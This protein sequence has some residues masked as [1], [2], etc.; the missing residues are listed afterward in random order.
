MDHLSAERR[1]RVPPDRARAVLE[2]R[3][4]TRGVLAPLPSERDQNYAVTLPDGR[5]RVLKIAHPEEDPAVLELQDTVLRRLR[6]GRTGFEFPVPLETVDGERVATVEWDGGV[7]RVRLMTWVPGVP[8]A[9]ARPRSPALLNRI[10]FMLGTVDRILAGLDVEAAHRTL[11][12]DLR[13]APD[14]IEAN[15]PCIAESDRR[16]LVSSAA[17]RAADRLADPAPG[18]R[19]AIVHNDANDH[20]VLVADV[21]GRP[22][23]AAGRTV[24]GLIDFG[25]LLH[26]WVVSEVAVAAAYA[27]LDQPDPLTAASALTGGYHAAHP[28]TEAELQA[29]PH[30][31]IQ[32]LIV[33]VCLSAAQRSADPGNA[34]L[35][36]SEAPAWALLEALQDRTPDLF[37]CLLRH[38]CGL[39][40]HPRSRSVVGW[41]RAHGREAAPV[42]DPDPASVPSLVFDLSVESPELGS[43]VAGLD[44]RG[45][46]ALLFGRMAER[47]AK[48]GI[49][50]YD[51]A[52]RWYEGEAYAVQGSDAERRTLHIGV[53][54]FAPPGTPVRAPLDGTVH[55]IADN[56]APLDYGPTLILEHECGPGGER[57]HTLFGHL[58]AGVLTGL[59]PG[60][61]VRAGDVV[62]E[63][64]DLPGN[65]NWPP[66]LH[67]QIVV[68]L[69]GCTGDFPGVAPPAQRDVWLS[70]SP[71]PNLL[72]GLPD[73]EPASR[74]ATVDDLLA[75]RGRSLGPSLSVSYHE[76]LKIVRGQGALLLDD[77]GRSYL[78]CVNNVAH[79]GHCHPR[80][81]AAAAEQMGVLN[82]NTRYL[83]EH[84]VRY[85]ERLASTLPDPLQV[86][87]FVCSGSEANEL[88]LRM[89]QAH[90]ARRDVLVLDGAYHGNTSS[91]IELSPYKFDGPG[92]AGAP[93]HVHVL[94][95]P[96][97]YR[98]PVRRGEDWMAER[99]AA[100]VERALEAIAA[101]G[102]APAAFF[103]ESVPSCAGQIVLPEG[104]LAL[105]AQA[106]RRA[107][108]V[109][110][111]D[112][113][114]VG[115]GR[116]G[117]HFWGFET[118]GVVPDIV[119][120]GKPMG[121]GHP[122]GA[123]V[124]TPEIARSFDNGMEYFNTFGGNPV[125]C[126]VGLAVLDVIRDEGL[127]ERA[128]SVGNGLLAGLQALVDRHAILGDAR[129]LGL[130]LGLELVLDRD[131]RTPAPA[132]AAHLVERMRRH[133]ILLST[134]GPDHNVIK[135][136]PPLVFDERDAQRLIQV[137]D[138]VLQE[139]AFQLG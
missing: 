129:G 138:Q 121:N 107:G 63:V 1:P 93:E 131:A 64:G 82:T 100:A 62:A 26:T 57:F 61:A 42:L 25:D 113:V 81:V 41:L 106:V 45:F 72:L 20:N 126:A 95:L 122:M 58:S 109:Y 2:T 17:R 18:L 130:F 53:D 48:V 15:A 90:T 127:Q 13:R 73:L 134:D 23:A 4:A 60:T 103:A 7:H 115:F 125:S 89:A 10:G 123:V 101:R 137:L 70:L 104:Y 19:T 3:F 47:G 5:R 88:A 32:R 83:H 46:T 94:T 38:A 8:L 84:L 37:E 66:H 108:G 51:E 102:S 139:D 16:T 114:Q 22:A 119:T 76:P 69:L 98:G 110:V 77:M 24:E 40:P 30:L 86:C 118:Q 36:V 54:L 33:S 116:V 105:A 80:V 120:M 78:D 75:R 28:L 44:A 67:F 96:D 112:E 124:T 21:R 29:L 59:S 35:S 99:Y 14:V 31:V 52:R 85:A 6:D 136:K 55:S 79:V 56:A 12:W 128:R 133:G 65:G 49:G 68:D 39:E 34:Y 132:H 27:M 74:G 50:R 9:N 135:I 87:F 71:D 43:T 91:L 92:G 117:T 111:A 97:P 11:R